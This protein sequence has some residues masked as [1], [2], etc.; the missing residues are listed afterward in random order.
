MYKMGVL[1]EKRFKYAEITIIRNI[2]DEDIFRTLSRYFGYENTSNDNDT[3][4]MTFD[5]GHI[6]DIKDE[7][8]D[9]KYKFSK[10]ISIGTWFPDYFELN[11]KITLFYKKPYIK[12]GEKILDFKKILGVCKNYNKDSTATSEYNFIYEDIY[13][14]DIFAICKL[15]SNEEKPRFLLAYDIDVLDRSNIIYLVD[16]IFKHKFVK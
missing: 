1:N 5:D 16:C 2:A 11:N 10:V 6:C 12:D 8:K 7:Y 13:K 9:L 14:K 15:K 3:I 4:I